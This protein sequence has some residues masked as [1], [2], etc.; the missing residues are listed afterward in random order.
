MSENHH[1]TVQELRGLLEDLPDDVDLV[2]TLP[3]GELGDELNQ[4]G[5]DRIAAALPAELKA[6]IRIGL[7]YLLDEYNVSGVAL[8]AFVD[9][10][11]ARCRAFSRK[12]AKAQWDTEIW[13]AY[14]GGIP[15][16][17]E[18]SVEQAWWA[19]LIEV[20]KTAI[21]VIIQLSALG[22]RLELDNRRLTERLRVEGNEDRTV[23]QTVKTGCA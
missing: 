5:V 8:D 3:S 17:F 10:V 22:I 23:T 9:E 20:G 2:V 16:E 11:E 13:K 18:C 14:S 4:I 19:S 12:L 21:D 15:T 1:C 6:Q 7:R